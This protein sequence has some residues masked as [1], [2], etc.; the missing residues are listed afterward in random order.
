SSSSSSLQPSTARSDRCRS[1]PPR[2]P[3]SRRRALAQSLDA[4]RNLYERLSNPELTAEPAAAPADVVYVGRVAVSRYVGRVA[5]E[6][7][8]RPPVEADKVYVGRAAI[9]RY[10]GRVAQE[11][12]ESEERAA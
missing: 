11:A 4:Y 10:V 12:V 6:L 2:P 1:A 5:K 8:D 9:E 7:T 3:S